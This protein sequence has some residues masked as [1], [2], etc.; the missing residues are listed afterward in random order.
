MPRN[1]T[2]TFDDGSTHVYREVPDDA[3]PEQVTA[4]AQRDTGKSVAALDGGRRADANPNMRAIARAP[5]LAL[6][7]GM[8]GAGNMASMFA[9][10]IAYAGDKALG[11]FGVKPQFGDQNAVFS[12][13]ANAAGLP[14]PE[15]AGER[16]VGD[17]SRTLAAAMTGGGVANNLAQSATGATQALLT[18]FGANLPQQAASAVGA[19]LVGGATREG[20]GGPIEQ[21]AAAVLGGV[22]GG[23][24]YSAAESAAGKVGN[25]YR[26]IVAPRDVA[27]TIEVQLRQSGVDWDALSTQAKLQLVNDAKEAVQTGRPMSAD[28]MRRLADFRQIGATPTTGEITQDP[29]LITT[30]RNLAKVQASMPSLGDAPDLAMM[31]HE[32]AKKVISALQGVESSPADAF[33]AG[34]MV[35]GAVKGKDSAT[36]QAVN[37]LYAQARDSAGRAIPLDRR[38]FINEA[39]N[40]LVRENKT[41]FL[42]DGV[43]SLLNQISTGKASVNGQEFDVPFD[44]NTIDSLKTTL[45]N[46]ATSGDGNVRAA[47]K[48]VRMA[49]DNVAPHLDAPQV[50]GQQVVTRQLAGAMRAPAE[51]LAAFDKAR[52]ASRAQFNWRESAPF[53]ADALEGM[54]PQ[55]FVKRHITG[56]GYQD[57]Q[58]LKKEIGGNPELL[59][60]VRRQLVGYIMQAGGADADVTKF[61]SAGM[62]RALDAIGPKL[63][64]FFS[65]AEIQT[66][67]SAVNV[68]KYMQSQPIGSA[69]NNSNSGVYV[70]A[71][72]LTDLMRKAPVIG[73]LVGD[74]AAQYVTG[75]RAGVQARQAANVTNALMQP[76]ARQPAIP[77]ATLAAALSA[78]RRQDDRRD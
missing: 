72:M 41:A 77:T 31:Q 49:L 13:A 32:N 59:G 67:R 48:A 2:I 1:V 17:A 54:D 51:S 36:S 23:L 62:Q 45:A 4:R 75:V 25:A 43:R 8:E 78:H 50:G 5:G 42:P 6:R 29:R 71:R 39:M 3:T 10:P 21:F 33:Q 55:T 30:Q 38:A 52:A 70:V 63:P 56:A 57:L 61:S 73:P 19:G 46:A 76:R 16:V 24:G 20:G 35:Q 34:Q 15:N 12:R 11:L 64:V 40:N 22:A 14:S 53:V 47:V 27:A 26:A 44:V 9:N 58:T 28:A 74:P 37:A 68:G 69:V 66:I 18:R 60:A 7:Y 65:P